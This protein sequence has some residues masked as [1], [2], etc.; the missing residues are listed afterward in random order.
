MEEG[1]CRSLR[2]RQEVIEIIKP[3]VSVSKV[4]HFGIQ[5][6]RVAGYSRFWRRHI[7]YSIGLEVHEVP[8]LVDNR[9]V[10]EA[11]MVLTID[12]SRTI[13]A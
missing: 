8:F 5:N 6:V 3:S 10:L 13:L 9:D 12:Q 7:G 2:C 11:G 4:F 1:I